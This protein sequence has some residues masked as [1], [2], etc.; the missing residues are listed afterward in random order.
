MNDILRRW[1]FLPE[2]ATELS[3]RI[4]HLHFFV[5]LTTFVVST[6]I[7]LTAVFFMVRYRRRRAEQETRRIE[8]PGWLEALFIIVPLSLFLVWFRIGFAQFTELT[9]PPP[10]AM[11]VYVMAKQWMWKFAYPDGPNGLSVLKVPAGRPVRLLIT[12]R[13]V[14][15]SFFVPAFRLKQDALPGR[16]TQTWFNATRPGVYPVFC[17]EYCGTG[18]STM[19]AEVQVVEAAEFD[20]WLAEQQKGRAAQR[21][22]APPKPGEGP[23]SGDLVE[24]GKHAALKKGC[25]KCHSIDGSPHIGPSWLDLYYAKRTLSNGQVVIADEAYLTKSMMEPNVDIV[26]GYKPV[27]PSF[28]GNLASAEAAAIVEY[29][30]SLRADLLDR[31]PERPIYEPIPAGGGDAH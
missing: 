19:R 9:T 13:D 21:D 29:I 8:P 27:M 26:A 31:P 16:Y 18:H 5:M 28:H 17:A 6:V 14:I 11:D 23:Q 25:L 3:V 1:L 12:S 10:D 30:K 20:R 15:H 24:Q 7:G 22:T 2:Q 4:D